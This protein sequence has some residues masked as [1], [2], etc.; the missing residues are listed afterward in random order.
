M[1][2]IYGYLLVVLQMS[3]SLYAMDEKV[4][5]DYVGAKPVYVT[6][7]RLNDTVKKFC[8]VVDNTQNIF[9][10][11]DPD[12]HDT[13]EIKPYQRAYALV[14]LKWKC[15]SDDEKKFISDNHRSMLRRF[16][17]DWKALLQQEGLLNQ[18]GTVDPEIKKIVNAVITVRRDHVQVEWPDAFGTFVGAEIQ[19]PQPAMERQVKDDDD[20]DNNSTVNG[21]TAVESSFE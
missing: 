13:T 15:G 10:Q 1:R 2:L 20:D 17:Q 8:S 19:Q 3:L 18:N 6:R 21:A 16:V 14:L 4:L 5:L 12:S 11:Q 9:E 7:A